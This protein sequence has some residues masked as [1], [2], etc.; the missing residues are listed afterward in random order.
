MEP[1]VAQGSGPLCGPSEMAMNRISTVVTAA[2]VVALVASGVAFAQGPRGGGPGG[3]GG[4]RGGQDGGPGLAL[5]GLNLTDAQQQQI[6]D[7]RQQERESVRE[8]QTKRRA[9]TEVQRR[10][11]E[12]VPVNE[13][14]I[15]DAVAAVAEIETEVAIKQAHVFNQIWSVLTREQQ[16]QALKTR[17]D[18]AAREQ[19]RQARRSR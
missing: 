2:V 19:S 10:V 6:R 8:L 18:R 1:G 14:A 12:A 15:R 7:I 4:P 17:A 13:G 16:A 11:T 9:A 3:P 5:G